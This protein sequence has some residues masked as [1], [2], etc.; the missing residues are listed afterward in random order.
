MERAMP[1]F[2]AL[3]NASPEF[4]RDQAQLGYSYKD[5]RNPDYAL[6]KVHL[7]KAIKLR[8]PWQEN[9]YV[10]Y[11]LNRALCDI[12]RESDEGLTGKSPDDVQRS[13]LEDLRAAHVAAKEA[14]LTEILKE[15][16]IIEW[17]RRNG[18]ETLDLTPNSPATEG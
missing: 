2:K 6:A 17:L 12:Y 18:I 8:G 1:V 11:E 9:G 7:T 5:Q 14:G 3:I 10:I 16:K 15:H 13:V 4:H